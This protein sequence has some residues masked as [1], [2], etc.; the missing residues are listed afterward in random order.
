MSPRT[1]QLK[2]KAEGTCYQALLDELRQDM[3]INYLRNK[4]LPVGDIA[5]LLGFSEPSSF[6]RTSKRWTGFTPCEFRRS[7]DEAPV[8]KRR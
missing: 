3:A 8:G 7:N 6:S 5:Y 2:L 1:L 4:D